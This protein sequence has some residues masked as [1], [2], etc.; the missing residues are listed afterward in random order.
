V[1][2]PARRRL[3]PVP[4]RQ[5]MVL[6]Q[7]LLPISLSLAGERAKGTRCY[8]PGRGPSNSRPFMGDRLL[9]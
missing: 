3:G 1:D 2:R 4:I 8:A 6:S 5:I 9:D 7:V